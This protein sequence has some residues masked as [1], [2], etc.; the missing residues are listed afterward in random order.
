MSEILPKENI[1]QLD[2]EIAAALYP[3]L[4]SLAHKGRSTPLVTYKEL[5]ELAG[6]RDPDNAAIK[7][8][9][10]VSVGRRLDVIRYFTD[11]LKLPDM[12][13]LVVSQDTGECGSG[14]TDHF[15]PEH[16]RELVYSYDWSNVDGAFRLYVEHSR[17]AAAKK[18]VNRDRAIQ[19]IAEYYKAHKQALPKDV[20][21]LREA[22]IE[23]V[24]EGLPIERAF[25]IVLEQHSSGKPH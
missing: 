10:P 18:P 3:V 17:I 20:G 2:V 21:K 12:T 15:D 16:A 19:S 14:F 23:Q 6:R 8:C 11:E 1:T 13:C 24:M 7:S 4:V 9:I 5:I 25:E 22:L